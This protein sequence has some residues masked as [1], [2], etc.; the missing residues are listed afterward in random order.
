[1]YHGVR[2]FIIKNVKVESI[3]KP[4]M[5]W[6]LKIKS[7]NTSVRF[8]GQAPAPTAIAMIIATII[9]EYIKLDWLPE[10]DQINLVAS[11]SKCARLSW[12]DSLVGCHN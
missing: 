5:M 12:Q 6:M 7:K 1:M 10:T 8:I 11:L 2:S 3:P 9:T 4:A